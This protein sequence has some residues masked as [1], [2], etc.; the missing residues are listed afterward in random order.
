MEILKNVVA[1]PFF[2]GFCLGFLFF[3][4]S[5]VA[6]WKTKRE[7]RRFQRHL[8]DK[9]ELEAKQYNTAKEECETLK[10][11]NEN[12]RLKIG[13]LAEKPDTKLQRDVEIMVRAEKRMMISAP[14]FAA[15]WETA[16]AES[17]REVETEESGKSV[18][19]RFF[20]KLFGVGAESQE[21]G[22]STTHTLTEKADSTAEAKTEEE[23]ATSKS[24]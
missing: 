9:M 18:P 5:F 8:S 11:E 24:S 7:Y 10:K 1:H 21:T 4:L 17:A 20:T 13:Q 2:W 19:K 3:V 12:L 16:K 22:K 14:G 6:H 23:P 15:A